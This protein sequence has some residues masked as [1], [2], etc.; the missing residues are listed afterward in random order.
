MPDPTIEILRFLSKYQKPASIA[1]I[2]S[3]VFHQLGHTLILSQL[4]DRMTEKNWI[5]YNSS[6]QYIITKAGNDKLKENV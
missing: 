2:N 6:G 4:L 5:T 3:E 1:K